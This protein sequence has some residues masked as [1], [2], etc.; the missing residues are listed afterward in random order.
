MKELIVEVSL[1]SFKLSILPPLSLNQVAVLEMA[2]SPLVKD[3]RRLGFPIDP[4]DVTQG[5][6]LDTPH[7]LLNDI[8]VGEAPVLCRGGYDAMWRVQ[9]RGGDLDVGYDG[10][11]EFLK[12][13][14]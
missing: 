4:T 3:D 8:V 12:P 13:R 14:L 5:H 7:E 6:A 11:I 1:E 9:K 2:V 10:F